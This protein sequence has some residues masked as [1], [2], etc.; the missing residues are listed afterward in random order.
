MEVGHLRYATI[1]VLLEPGHP[2]SALLKLAA[3][4]AAKWR[5]SIIGMAACQPLPMTAGEIYISG[6]IIQQD[7]DDLEKEI[8]D[9]EE[10]FHDRLKAHSGT[11]EWR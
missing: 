8:K 6:T 2:N 11:T 4:L 3:D 9:A 5:S 10:E 1:I 7:R